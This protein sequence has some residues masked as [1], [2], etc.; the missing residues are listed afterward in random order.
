MDFFEKEMR[1]M[2]EHTS[3]INDQVFVG[4]TMMARLDDN[5]LLKFLVHSLGGF[6]VNRENP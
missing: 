5:K 4:K 1:Q 6:A 3:S 2:F